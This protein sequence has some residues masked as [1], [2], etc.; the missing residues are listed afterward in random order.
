[1]SGTTKTGKAIEKA[2]QVF[3]ESGSRKVQEVAQ[4]AIV[5][6][7]GH[8]HDNPVPASRK[9]RKNGILLMT[10]GIGQHV[11]EQ[12]LVEMTGDKDLAFQDVLSTESLSQFTNQFRRITKGEKCDFARGKEGFNVVCSPDRII[13]G[14]SLKNRFRGHIFVEDHFHDPNCRANSTTQEVDLSIDLANCG[15]IVQYSLDPPGILFS[16]RVILKLH[17]NFRTKKDF[18]LDVN[19]FYP[20][21]NGLIEQKFRG[22][23]DDIGIASNF[24]DISSPCEYYFTTEREECSSKCAELHD[25]LVHQWKCSTVSPTTKMLVH[26]CFIFDP[27]SQKSKMIIDSD[28]CSTDPSV[29]STPKYSTG[30]SAKADGMVIQFPGAEYIQARCTISFCTADQNSDC[31]D[32]QQLKCNKRRSKRQTAPLKKLSFSDQ[33]LV[34]FDDEDEDPVQ[35]DIYQDPFPLND[36]EAVASAST[37]P[38]ISTST[39]KLVEVTTKKT[40]FIPFLHREVDNSKSDDIEISVLGIPLETVPQGEKLDERILAKL[41]ST[42]ILVESPLL[43]IATKK[44]VRKSTNFCRN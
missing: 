29:I 44:R 5:V 4:V 39:S 19:C 16:T 24:L 26:S 38:D 30:L 25:N 33:P 6:S 12:E 15:M 28:G 20:E 21:N 40:V 14:A 34:I 7:D 18:L 35:Q 32:F 27:Y 23:G 10:L 31:F 42:Q 3:S 17:P 11:N 9:L 13:V 36:S 8:S 37:D 1:M 41:F 2:L 22:T 43:R